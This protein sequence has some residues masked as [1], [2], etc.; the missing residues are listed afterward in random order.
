L[1]ATAAL[2]LRASCFS[3]LL[4]ESP[5]PLPPQ[6]ASKLLIKPSATVLQTAAFIALSS[7]MSVMRRLRGLR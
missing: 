4:R 1:Q 3:L 5:D 6:P 2:T 7:I